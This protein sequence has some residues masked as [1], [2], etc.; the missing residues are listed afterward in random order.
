LTLRPPQTTKTYL[1]APS[2]EV[3]TLRLRA[4]RRSSSG[5]IIALRLRGSRAAAYNSVGQ[6]RDPD[7]FVEARFPATADLSS[8]D[9]R[10]EAGIAIA[11][12]HCR[13]AERCI[14]SSFGR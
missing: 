9:D 12:G 13:P 4:D 5:L 14:R 11:P 7:V 6:R 8:G 10:V 3:S 2:G 1:A